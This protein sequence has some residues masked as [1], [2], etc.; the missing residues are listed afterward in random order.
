MDEILS[1]WSQIEQKMT[2]FYRFGIELN[3]IKNERWNRKIVETENN[4]ESEKS[5]LFNF[6]TDNFLDEILSFWN[7]IERKIIKMI[8]GSDKSV[9][10][11]SN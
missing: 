7:W 1:F 9:R 8:V 4:V 10:F 11:Q 6:K 5:V 3:T 2:K